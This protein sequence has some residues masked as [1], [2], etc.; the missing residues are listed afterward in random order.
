MRQLVPTPAFRRAYRKFVR[1]NR[2]LEERIE[3]TLK[4]MEADVF[5]PSLG[6]HRLSGE[7]MGLRACSCGFDCRIIFRLEVD[8]ETES[9]MILLLDIGTHDEV[10]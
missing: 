3:R 4:L 2:L 8:P 7:L 10:Y 1:R 6:T 9:E 5:A